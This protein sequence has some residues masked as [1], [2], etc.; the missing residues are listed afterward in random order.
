MKSYLS[1]FKLKFITGLQY[2]AAALAGMATQLFFG[3]AFI[4]VYIACYNSGNNNLPME[5]SKLVSYL[6]LCQIFFSFTYVFYR[7]K[8][9]IN[10]II[11]G[12]ISYELCRPQD[13]YFMW[14]ARMYGD[15][16]SKVI[17]RFLPIL[18]IAVILP[19][20][21]NLNLEISLYR[22]LIFIIIF[23]LSSILI[24]SL[25]VLYHVICIFT[26][27]DRGIINIFMVIADILSGSFVPVPFFPTFIQKINNYLP[28][29][30]I[31]DFPFRFYV[32]DINFNECYVSIIVQII[33]IFILMIT[34]KLLMKKALKKAVIQGG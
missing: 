23:I 31:S 6:W 2:R 28:F 25:S 12:N 24:T 13:L 16:L 9:I 8:E 11:S 15:R 18:C 7:D 21:Y 5:L 20:P 27:D 30:Y 22:F 10:M 17:L 33:W 19:N 32:G 29:R 1:Y 26:L 3:F 4:S 34:G 14:L